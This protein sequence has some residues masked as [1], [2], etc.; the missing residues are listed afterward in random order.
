MLTFV[1]MFPGTGAIG[2][3]NF[4]SNFITLFQNSNIAD[5]VWIN[6]P[7][8]QLG[9][10]QKESE[11]VAYAINYISGISGQKNVSVLGEAPP[12]PT[13]PFSHSGLL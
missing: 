10:A 3:E 5:P 11:V 2:G 1:R 13:L 6:P 9:D 7:T 8:F 4:E 12:H